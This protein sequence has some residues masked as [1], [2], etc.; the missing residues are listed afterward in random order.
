MPPSLTATGRPTRRS[1]RQAGQNGGPARR[2][3][4]GQAGTRPKLQRATRRRQR[5]FQPADQATPTSATTSDPD[6][7]NSRR[8]RRRNREKPRAAA[9]RA[10]AGVHCAGTAEVAVLRVSW[11]RASGLLDLRDEGYGFLRTNGYLASATDVYV[12]ITQVRRYGV[13][14]GR[15]RRGLLPARGQQRKVPG[16]GQGGL[17]RRHGARTTPATGRSSRT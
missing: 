3:A 7:G 9:S 1:Q 5:A 10:G 15:P 2:A 4:D 17:R 13:A 12:S 16:A 14:Q 6:L 8:R 11:C